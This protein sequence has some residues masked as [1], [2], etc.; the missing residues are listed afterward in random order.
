LLCVFFS[1]ACLLL[2]LLL[3][4]AGQGSLCPGGYADF[5]QGWLWE[6]HVLLIAHLW[7][8]QVGSEPVPGSREPSW[9]LYIL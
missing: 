3:L 9:F 8:C 6:N 4:F 5:S 1:V 2:L 7:V